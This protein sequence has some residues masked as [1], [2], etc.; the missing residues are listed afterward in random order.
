MSVSCQSSSDDAI[1]STIEYSTLVEEI[2][3]QISP[4]STMSDLGGQSNY[5]KL[6]QIMGIYHTNEMTISHAANQL[7]AIVNSDTFDFMYCFNSGFL[8]WKFLK[9]SDTFMK[10][11]WYYRG[12][13]IAKIL[14]PRAKVDE[15]L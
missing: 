11:P 7:I 14:R 4:Q 1:S 10:A 8:L 3:Q 13:V 5:D 9:S 12:Y 6:I 2:E 15:I